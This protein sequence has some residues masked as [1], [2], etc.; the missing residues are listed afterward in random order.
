MGRHCLANI[1]NFA[2]QAFLCVWPTQQALP[3][4]HILLVNVFE[5]FQK[6]SL[7]VT[8]KKNVCQARVRVVAKPTNIVICKQKFKCLPNYVCPFDQDLTGWTDLRQRRA[9]MTYNFLSPENLKNFLGATHIL[10]S[11]TMMSDRA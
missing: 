8:S 3:D 5:M 6:H 9:I 11:T 7:L 2:C 10:A 4:K 1:S